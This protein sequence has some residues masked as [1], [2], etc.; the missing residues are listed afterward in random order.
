MSVRFC[1][2]LLAA[3]VAL[4]ACGGGGA[5]SPAPAAP[6]GTAPLGKAAIQFVIPSAGSAAAGGRRP[7]Y[8]PATTQSVVVTAMQANGASFSPPIQTIINASS[9]VPGSG[10]LQCNGS[11]TVPEQALT[12]SIVGYAAPNGQGVPTANALA[13]MTVGP[14]PNALNVTLGSAAT[15]NYVNLSGGTGTVTIDQQ[16]TT[17]IETNAAGLT[18]TGTVQ[19]LPS[20]GYDKLQVTGGTDT[21]SLG[22]IAYVKESPVGAAMYIS[23][24]SPGTDGKILNGDAGAA[25]GTFGSCAAAGSFPF[26]GVAIG[27]G[28]YNATSGTSFTVGNATI[29]G[30]GATAALSFAGANYTLG[31]TL[32]KNASGTQSGCTN[33]FFGSASSGLVSVGL[34]GVV[35]VGNNS[36][37]NQATSN[38]VGTIGFYAPAQPYSL[39]SLASFSYDS[40][41]GAV[42]VVSGS[43]QSVEF[44]QFVTPAGSNSLLACPYTTFESGAVSTS[45]CTTIVLS[46]QPLPG[47]VTG[48]ATNGG[49][50]APFVAAV[51]IV[52]G[53]YMI[54][55]I[56]ANSPNQ[57]VNFVM[58]QH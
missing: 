45:N 51:G 52:N 7:N 14:G 25:T 48:T 22:T 24:Q 5:G 49:T 39:S 29:S 17:F 3:A 41:S 36:S 35:V 54:S 6:S 9:C 30:S 13:T 46:G 21:S 4:A 37:T 40:I 33:D 34:E 15:Y 58:M 27:G 10:G 16:A 11:I 28:A 44:P 53:K 19:S 20:I 2:T 43:I 57:A 42:A 12:F 32:I 55:V 50:T 47:I 26:V 38:D 31:G 23:G 8:L 18:S 56:G 1:A